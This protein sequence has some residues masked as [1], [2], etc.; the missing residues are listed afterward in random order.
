MPLLPEKVRSEADRPVDLLVGTLLAHADAFPDRPAVRTSAAAISY[1]ALAR[2]IRGAAAKIRHVLRHGGQ[3]VLLCGPNSPE[4]AAAY[5]A[6]HAAGGV[7]VLL[8]ADIPAESARWIAA[9][10]EARLALCRGNSTCPCRSPTW[11]PGAARTTA[12]QLA[13]PQCSLE[14]P[15]DLLY[16]TG[17]TGRKKGVLLSHANLAHAALNI[18]AF[19]DTSCDDLECVP[20]PL[21]HSFGLGRLR[22]D[23]P[24]RAIACCS[25][26]ACATRRRS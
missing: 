21:S 26:R 25:C 6:V 14:D 17:T 8:D 24:G 11:L 2:M 10:A 3:R 19:L 22:G 12:E 13:S 4:L 23:G 7:A 9:D 15:A 1:G 5:F 16:T 20:L 18:N